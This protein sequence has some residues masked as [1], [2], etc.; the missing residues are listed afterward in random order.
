MKASNLREQTDEELQQAYEATGREL[1]ELR[2]KRGLGESSAQPLR[3]RSVRRDIARIRTV[4]QERGLRA[5]V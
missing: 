3:I 4:M 2:G 1:L 5:N